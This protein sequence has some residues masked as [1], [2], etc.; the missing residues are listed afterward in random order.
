MYILSLAA[1]SFTTLAHVVEANS[2]HFISRETATRHVVFRPAVGH[3]SLPS[4]TVPGLD[5]RTQTFPTGWLGNFYSFNEGTPNVVGM[6]GE[7]A[8]DLD[9]RAWYDVSGVENPWD[10]EG[11]HVIW[12]ATGA[13][14]DT[15]M[16]CD[17]WREHCPLTRY[18]AGDSFTRGTSDHD[19]LCALGE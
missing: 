3:L 2:I 16:G 13:Y 19:L 7:V 12:A 4:L 8:F 17:I 6:L 10:T 5:Q 15:V 9:G 11:V 18:D 14:T 1:V